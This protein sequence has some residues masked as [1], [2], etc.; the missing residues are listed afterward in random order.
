LDS[1]QNGHLYLIFE[2]R[3]DA[4]LVELGVDPATVPAGAL[5]DSDSESFRAYSRRN[6]K[7]MA[8][9]EAL[10][11]FPD[12]AAIVAPRVLEAITCDEDVSFNRQLIEPITAAVGRRVVQRHLISVIESGALLERVCAV[13][14][15][16]WSQVTLV[17]RTWEDREAG[18]P[19]AQSRA[20]DDDV[21]DLRALY[22][23]A[24]LVAFIDC[25]DI[26]TREW[27]AHGCILDPAFYPASLHAAVA[28]V[29]QIAEAD[30]VRFA[31]LLS[32]KEDGTNLMA[33]GR[34]A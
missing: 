20:A 10:R 24:C 13:R 4:V 22:R 30:P 34:D 2:Q 3:L 1:G 18:R 21:A 25:D 33:V 28:Q 19:T 16:Y 27:L 31:N 14:A 12:R 17:Y 11:R 6:M 7:R 29:R 32:K 9:S 8:V 23:A 5:S 26:E 15:W